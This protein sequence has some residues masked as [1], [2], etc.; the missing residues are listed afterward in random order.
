MKPKRAKTVDEYIASAPKEARAMLK[1]LRRVIKQ[2]APKAEEKISYGMPY[3]SYYGRLAY[4][5]AYKKHCSFFWIGAADKQRYKKELAG[6]TVVGNTLRFPLGEC[7]RT[8]VVKK[9]VQAR[10]K[11]NEA[12][13]KK[14]R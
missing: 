12:K 8:S 11:A 4:I 13:R 6:H 9:I 1:E 14:G 10:A 5:G 7:M 3:Y 2:A